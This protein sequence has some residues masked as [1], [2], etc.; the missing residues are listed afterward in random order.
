MP[1]CNAEMRTGF[2]KQC[3]WCNIWKWSIQI[4]LLKNFLSFDLAPSWAQN[5]YYKADIKCQNKVIY[6]GNTENKSQFENFLTH[7]RLEPEGQ[8]KLS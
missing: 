1:N 2:Q 4:L 5:N 8:T 3:F 6:N 7:H